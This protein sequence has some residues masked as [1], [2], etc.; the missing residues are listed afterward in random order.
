MR[1]LMKSIFNMFAKKKNNQYFDC[2]DDVLEVLAA[3]HK[4]GSRITQ[5]SKSNPGECQDVKMSSYFYRGQK[6]H[7]RN[8]T[9]VWN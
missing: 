6:K 9:V 2:I 5:H 3:E 1:K 8:T 7:T 4:E